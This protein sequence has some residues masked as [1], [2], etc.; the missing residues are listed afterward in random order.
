ML[1]WI[2]I[3]LMHWNNG[4]WIDLS[5]HSDEVFG[6]RAKPVSSITHKY[7][8]HDGEAEEINILSLVVGGPTYRAHDRCTRTLGKRAKPYFT[9]DTA[10]Q[11]FMS[12]CIQLIKVWADLVTRFLILMSH[13]VFKKGYIEM[14]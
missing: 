4:P 9:I 5:I 1:S 3:I 8:A 2:S 14:L 11:I 12:H 7:Y 10:C 6:F 13:G